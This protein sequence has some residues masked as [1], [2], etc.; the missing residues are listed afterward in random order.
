MKAMRKTV[1]MAAFLLLPGIPA[2]AQAPLAAPLAE[3]DK[4]VSQLKTSSVV[5]DPIRSG[6]VAVIPFA[7]VQFGLGGGQAAI[8]FAGGMGA[9]TVPLGI[10]VV[11]GDDVRAE[12]FPEPVEKPSYL[13]E[14]IQAILDRKVSFMVNGVNLGEMSGS[15]QDL[16]P[17]ISA[18]T[19]Q[20]TV[21]V[22]ALN[23][24]EMNTP[25]SSAGN[26]SLGELTKLFNA[27]KYADALAVADA[28]IAKDPKNADAHAW[29][30]RM[31]NSL[32]QANPLDMLKYGMGA[33]DEFE[34]ALSLD[35]H[36]R[37]AFLGRGIARLMAPPGYGGDVDGAIADFEKA[38]AQQPS[39]QAYYYLGEALKNKGLKDSAAAAYRKALELL[40]NDP[41]L[42]KAV[43]ALK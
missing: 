39:P 43:A 18:M 13:H 42:L 24:G 30:G 16:A 10:L 3:F 32:A 21:M 6:D 28:L 22:Q 40:P 9:K 41:D 29:R 8:A 7:K 4:L 1:L 20:T 34:K 14:V 12:M 33:G 27:K 23:L 2:R 17:L 19:G 11:E 15:V 26:P 5:G 38:I 37:V 36:N 31:M 25:A 35:P